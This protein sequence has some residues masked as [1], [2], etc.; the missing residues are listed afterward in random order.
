[1]Q[2]MFSVFNLE[3]KIVVLIEAWIYVLMACKSV[4][5]VGKVETLLKQMQWGGG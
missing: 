1:M 5:F 4:H 2:S 3:S